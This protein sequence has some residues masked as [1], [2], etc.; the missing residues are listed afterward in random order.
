MNLRIER[1]PRILKAALLVLLLAPAL[2]GAAQDQS[3]PEREKAE[4][5]LAQVLGEIGEL[6]TQLESARGDLHAE[7]ARLKQLDLALQQASLEYRSLEKQQEQHRSDLAGLE[8]QKAQYLETLDE[9]TARLAEQVRSAYRTGNRSKTQLILN[10]DD[11]DRISRML[12]YYDYI[13]RAHTEKIAGLR[14]AVATLD[15]LQ[16]GIDTEIQRIAELQLEQ[17]ARLEELAGQRRQREQLLAELSGR[18]S[19]DQSELAEL[20]KDRQDLETLIERLADMLADI[21]DDLGSR[22]G[23]AE[24]KGQLRMPVQGPVRHAY[25]QR[26]GAGLNRQGWLIGAEPGQEVTAVAYGRVAFADWLRGYGLLLIIDHGQGYMSLYGHNE[27]L[28]QD[29]GAWVEPGDAISVV[30]S[31]PGSGQGLYF[32]LRRN[33]KAID[34]A[35]WMAR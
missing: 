21:P 18:I 27:S 30:G 3:D 23:I 26:R 8:Q 35:A 6:K 7:Q 4:Q 10:Q 31:N 33:G 13:H 15:G 24:Q 11:P 16:Q 19:N 34:P 9:R 25:G 12:A 1:I 22:S 32:E 29:A 17:Q 14:D 28:L 20:E 2:P 5:R